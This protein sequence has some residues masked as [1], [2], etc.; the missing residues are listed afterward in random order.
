MVLRNTL[1]GKVQHLKYCIQVLFLTAVFTIQST[2]GMRA[3]V[4]ASIF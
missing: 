4:A 1:V 2:C 3:G